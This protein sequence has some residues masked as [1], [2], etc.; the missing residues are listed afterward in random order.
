VSS[1][2]GVPKELPQLSRVDASWID[3]SK[4]PCEDY[5]QYA[6]SK[7]IAGHPIPADLPLTWTAN[8][9]LLYNQT[10]LGQAMEK[11]AENR[12]ATGSERQLGDFWRS[13]MDESGR[14][15]NEKTWLRPALNEIASMKSK[16]D[17]ARVLAYL[18]LN[19]GT[20]WL[21]NLNDTSTQVPFFGF[22]PRQDMRD[23]TRMVGQIDQGG[24]ALDAVSDYLDRS[25]DVEQLRGKYLAHIQKMFLL[26]GDPAIRA[27]AEAKTVVEIE[28]ALAQASMDNVSRRDPMKRYNKRNMQQLKVAVPAF[29]WEEYFDGIGAP[30]VPFYIV[31]APT[32]LPA[33]QQ[34]I[35][36]RSLGDL[37]TYLRWWT[38]HLA[39]PSLGNDFEHEDFAFFGTSLFGGRLA[40]ASQMLPR[41]QRCAIAADESLGFGALGKAYVEIAFPGD[42][43]QRANEMVTRIRAALSGEIEHLD[44]MDPTTKKQAVAKEEATLQ[45]IGYPDK[46][47]DYSSVTIVPDNY[48]AN[49]RALTNFEAR[50][51]FTKI[52]KPI[53][54]TEWWMPWLTPASFNAQEDKQMNRINFPTGIL[55]L[56]MFGAEQDEATNYGGAGAAIG[57]EIIHGFDDQGRKFD[58][59]GNLRNWWTGEDAKRYEQKDECIVD[60]YTQEVPEYGLKQ[61]GRLTAGE[62]TADNGGLHLAMLALEA[63]YREEGKSLDTPDDRGL[64]PRQ[65][66]FFSY[67]FNWCGELRQEAARQAL[68]ADTRSLLKFRLNRPLSNLPEFQKAYSC[69]SGQPMVHEPRCQVW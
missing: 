23:A 42:S 63:L 2:D 22:G 30:A 61:N 24:M 9:V 66:F 4:D 16:Q 54:R 12:Q 28:T 7:W 20:V 40:G 51:Q 45:I 41:W 56:P 53:D 58:T 62:D 1:A 48:L 29:D 33:L 39:A 11:A 47:R 10:V 69:K 37:E 44:W 3:K 15:K 57:H 31:T 64:T 49:K 13:C 21:Q 59:E 35:S 18:H 14:N 36:G 55:Q 25:A 19:Y 27:A 46:W 32:F 38:V 34:Q 67:A 8:P 26:L 65:E 60:Q 68:V 17:L 52:G 6:C 43:K 5:F 50:R